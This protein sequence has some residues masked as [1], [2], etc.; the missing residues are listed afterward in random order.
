MRESLWVVTM[1]EEARSTCETFISWLCVCTVTHDG[2]KLN[3]LCGKF[4]ISF[5]EEN[6]FSM[7]I[8]CMISYICSYVLLSNFF[9]RNVDITINLLCPNLRPNI[10]M[11][12]GELF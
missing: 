4:G 2:L 6:F 9:Q 8:R 10:C 11:L 3:E 7:E 12:D 1:N 5:N